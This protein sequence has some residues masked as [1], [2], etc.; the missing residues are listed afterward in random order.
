M[1]KVKNV[2]KVMKEKNGR[3]EQGKKTG[4]MGGKTDQ[5]GERQKGESLK[6]RNEK[7]GDKRLGQ[8]I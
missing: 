6:E 4:K 2:K 8:G 3:R 7:G 1:K 5:R